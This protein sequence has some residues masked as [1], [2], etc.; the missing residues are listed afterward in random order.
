MRLLFAL[1]FKRITFFTVLPKPIIDTY[2]SHYS[3]IKAR[4]YV[5]TKIAT[6]QSY[7]L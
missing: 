7:R 4:G 6:P 3:T 5:K 1:F 2:L